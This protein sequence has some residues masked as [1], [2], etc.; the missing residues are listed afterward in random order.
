MKYMRTRA[1]LALIGLSTLAVIFSACATVPA[2]S[3]GEK[4]VRDAEKCL[5]R[6]DFCYV[7]Q[8]QNNNWSEATVYV[9]GQR[10]AQLPATMD[11]PT[12]LFVPRSILDGAG[13]L[14]VQV[15]LFPDTGRGT[16][17]QECPGRDQ[18]LSLT[19]E[20]NNGRFPLHVW[21]TP[22]VNR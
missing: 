14:V 16:S 1:A 4:A 22:V 17:T 8:A 2:L 5:Q 3:P 15:K 21:L 11:R 18:R 20:N 13:C 12:P 7:M 6:S 10:L 9:N 19:I